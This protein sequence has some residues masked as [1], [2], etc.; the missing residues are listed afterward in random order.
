MKTI[1][2]TPRKLIRYILFRERDG[3]KG[4]TVLPKKKINEILSHYKK[5]KGFTSF[6]EFEKVWDIGI[7]DD[8]VAKANRPEKWFL[9]GKGKDAL[10]V[11]PTNFKEIESLRVAGVPVETLTK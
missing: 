1:K 6:Q 9:Y 7:D 3:V 4:K 11:R 5:Q 2:E 8:I 10:V